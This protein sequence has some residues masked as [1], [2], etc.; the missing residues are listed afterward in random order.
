MQAFPVRDG[1]RT[2]GATLFLVD[3]SRL[4]LNFRSATPFLL[5]PTAGPG[6]QPEVAY[7]A[8]HCI[9]QQHDWL[10]QPCVLVTDAALSCT[11]HPGPDSLL[12]A[13][14]AEDLAQS[15]GADGL[16]DLL[17]RR[18]RA[19]LSRTTLSPYETNRPVTGGQFFGREHERGLL[20]THPGTNYLVMGMRRVGKTSLLQEVERQI[21]MG[22]QHTRGEPQPIFRKDAVASA[23]VVYVDC[24]PYEAT[25][26]LLHTIVR[27]LNP[28]LGQRF[29]PERFMLD[30]RACSR[31]GQL[32]LQILLDEVDRFIAL[33]RHDAWRTLTLLRASANEG[34]ARYIFAGHQQVLSGVVDRS[35]PLFNFATPVVLGAFSS[36]VARDL[37]QVPLGRLGI[38]IEDGIV[39]RVVYES[40][41]HPNILQF[42]CQS[43][44]DQCDA[45]R[46]DTVLNADFDWVLD[47]P[48]FDSFVM[49]TFAE[50]TSI[51]EK[52]L[53]L[54]SLRDETFTAAGLAQMLRRD[55]RHKLLLKDLALQRALDNL[56]YGGILDR[57]GPAYRLR[58]P[59]LRTL[60]GA[61]YDLGYLTQQVGIEMPEALARGGRG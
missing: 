31:K 36:T 50:N 38:G 19:Q 35:A 46:R 49:R 1:P 52:L 10:E 17:L 60:L 16:P 58:L 55:G 14:D 44:V 11:A 22:Q 4:R 6:S 9:R 15:S 2:D 33:D 54:A 8:A 34:Y 39:D 26:A 57:S 29:D 32:R 53:V 37:I 51:L 61:H 28:R 12:I 25:D 5:I 13:L 24:S 21:S 48:G 42:F 47:A 45:A 3:L 18:A 27:R 40:G 59:V 7:R 56:H 30:L 23:S 43:F 20:L 41:G